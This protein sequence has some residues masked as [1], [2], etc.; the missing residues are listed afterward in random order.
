M[1]VSTWR[2][3]MLGSVVAMLGILNP[4]FLDA[5]LLGYHGKVPS[6]ADDSDL[7]SS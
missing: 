5:V 2:T 3:G 4:D 6:I 1:S 7:Q